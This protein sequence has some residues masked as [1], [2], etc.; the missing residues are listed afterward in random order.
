MADHS[1][2]SG[3]I[4]CDEPPS[5]VGSS[6]LFSFRLDP[7]A[8]PSGDVLDALADL[9]IASVSRPPDRPDGEGDLH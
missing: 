4:R 8:K 5:V 2:V 1:P 7:N 9:L 6:D 3:T